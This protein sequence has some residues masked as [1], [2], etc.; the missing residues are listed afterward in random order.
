MTPIS[1]FHGVPR[2]RRSAAEVEH[3]SPR[4]QSQRPAESGELLGRERVMNA[5]SA[6]GD[7]E[8]SRNVHYR[9]LLTSVNGFDTSLT[10]V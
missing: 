6:L 5:V 1:P 3:T 10:D 2:T 8:D 9:R 7:I 4:L